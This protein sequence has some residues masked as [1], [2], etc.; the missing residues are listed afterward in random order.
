MALKKSR[1]AGKAEPLCIGT[2]DRQRFRVDIGAGALRVRQFRQKREQDRTRTGAEIGDV[3][4]TGPRAV[5]VEQ[6]ER[7]LDHSF[8]FRPRH[9]HGGRDGERQAPEFL[10]ADNARHVA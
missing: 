8:G 1:T 3:Q 4:R 5:A 10:L 2:G 7:Q 9:Q 6:C